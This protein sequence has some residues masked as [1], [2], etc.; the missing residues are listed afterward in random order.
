M[1][2]RQT[3][4]VWL[5]TGGRAIKGQMLGAA[6]KTGPL[7]DTTWGRWKKLHPD[8]LVMAPDPR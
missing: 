8:T 6:L 3:E 1:Y 7:L 5:Q 2:D 4:S